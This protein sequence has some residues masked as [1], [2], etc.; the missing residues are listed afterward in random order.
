M[1]KMMKKG[2]DVSTWQGNIDFNKL[3]DVEFIMIRAGFG[4]NNIDDCAINNA[5]GAKKHNIPFGLYWFSY[6]YTVE[7]AKQEANYC[8]DFADKYGATYPI[9]YDWEED[10][11]EYAKK[12]GV[13]PTDSLVEQMTIAFLEQVKKRGY[14]PILYANWSDLSWCYKNIYKKYDLWYSCPDVDKPAVNCA[15]WQYSWSKHYNGIYGDVDADYC[16]KDYNK[17]YDIHYDINDKD[18]EI[19][20]AQFNTIFWN[21]YTEAAKD[22]IAGKY[23]SGSERRKLLTQ[24]GYDY[25]FVQTIVNYMMRDC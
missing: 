13:N 17:S 7:M 25:D 18:K 10:S 2:I 21:K 23:K 1:V 4:K 11:V 22:V 19:L 3:S 24:A 9:A 16:Y 8:C 6:A 20:N 5:I 15:I 12:N 14:T